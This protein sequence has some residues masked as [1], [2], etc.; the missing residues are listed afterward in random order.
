MWKV[1]FLEGENFERE[2]RMGRDGKTRKLAEKTRNSALPLW[3]K[4]MVVG[5]VAK[6]DFYMKGHFMNSVGDWCWLF[7]RV[8]NVFACC[9]YVCD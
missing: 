3:E 1:C 4:V 5:R 7:A 2:R 8:C 6:G 9:M